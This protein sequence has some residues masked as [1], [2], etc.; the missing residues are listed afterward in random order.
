M[1]YSLFNPHKSFC[2]KLVVAYLVNVISAFCE[3]WRVINCEYLTDPYPESILLSHNLSPIPWSSIFSLLSLF[4][5]KRRLMGSHWCLSAL[6][7]V[8]P[9]LIFD[10]K[11]MRSPSCLYV[12]AFVWLYITFFFLFS[13]A[14]VVS[15]VSRRLVLPRTSYNIIY[16]HL[17]RIL[18]NCL[19]LVG[20][21]NKIL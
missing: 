8:Y 6:L 5:K 15:N 7:S 19:F 12:W 20:L 13:E 2:E 18:W 10:R 16:F 4:R 3:R 17:H 1:I 21:R 14:R 11:L 9:L